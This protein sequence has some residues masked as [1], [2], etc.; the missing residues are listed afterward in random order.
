M[1]LELSELK[2]ELAHFGAENDA[3]EVERGRRMLNITPDTGEFLAVLVRFGTARR[4]LEIGTSNGYSTLWLAEAAA[5]I[6]GHVT[7]LEYAEDK[8]AM[9]RD[10]FARSG[11]ADR[12][13]L[14]HDDAGPWLAEAADAS[15][16][17]LFLD[18]DRGQYAGWWPQL[19]RVLRPGGLLV[20]DNATSHAGEMEPLRTLLESDANFSTSLVPVGNGELLAVRNA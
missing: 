11:L 15:I 7:T 17:L 4:V 20:V 10:T 2:N 3:R 12:I 19:R 9:A 1:A 8:A 14:V 18:S 13:T 5:A 6:D 16:D